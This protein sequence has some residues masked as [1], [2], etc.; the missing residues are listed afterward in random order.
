LN[1]DKGTKMIERKRIISSIDS[2]LSISKKINPNTDLS[3]KLKGII[4]LKY[5]IYYETSRG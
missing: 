4:D 2:R 1:P 5:K 3:Q